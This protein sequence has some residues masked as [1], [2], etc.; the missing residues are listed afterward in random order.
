MPFDGSFFTRSSEKYSQYLPTIN[1]PVKLKYISDET[2]TSLD[3]D[4]FK[5]QIGADNLNKI[6]ELEKADKDSKEEILVGIIFFY[7]I[8]E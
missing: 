6:Q 3:A 5:T 7:S 8:P 2:E 4:T 1:F